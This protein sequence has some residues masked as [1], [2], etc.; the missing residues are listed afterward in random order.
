M[1]SFPRERRHAIF[2]AED[3]LLT[4]GLFAATVGAI[5]AGSFATSA[6]A[7]S[8][9]LKEEKPTIQVDSKD[10]SHPA[11][12]T[13]LTIDHRNQGSN[14]TRGYKGSE[15]AS[16]KSYRSSAKSLNAPST[17]ISQHGFHARQDKPQNTDSDSAQIKGNED[18]INNDSDQSI[19]AE[20]WYF[21][22]SKNGSAVVNNEDDANS[23]DAQ[24]S[25]LD[26]PGELSNNSDSAS[27]YYPDNDPDLV[28]IHSVTTTV[29]P[30]P[31]Q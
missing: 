27:S 12:K 21:D 10:I 17:N 20:D 26:D 3:V 22:E 24:C 19:D 5:A 8:K 23:F 13:L 31:M 6:W 16:I 28:P 2:G 29:W 11:P 14:S 1:Y 25:F 7:T 9:L 15:T 4:K 18:D 30:S